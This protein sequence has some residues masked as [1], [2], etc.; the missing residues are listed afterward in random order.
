MAMSFARTCRVCGTSLHGP[1]GHV[2]HLFGIRRSSRN[3]NVCN[4]CDAHFQDSEVVEI[5]ILFADLSGFT[6]LTNTVGPEKSFEVLQTFFSMAK[7]ALFHQD[8]YIDKFIGDAVM[9]FFN[10]PIRNPRHGVSA[11]K[12]A[13]A[14]QRGMQ[15]VSKSIGIDLK[16]RIGVASGRAKL[17]RL[18]GDEGQDFTVIGEA[19]NLAS[20]LQSLAEPGEILID[21]ATFKQCSGECQGLEPEWFQ[22]KGFD[23]PVEAYRVD[24]AR[25]LMLESLLWVA[26]KTLR[27]RMGLGSIL[28]TILGAPCA[29]AATLSPLSVVLGVVAATGATS[30]FFHWLDAAPI[31][32]PLQLLGVGGALM[33]LLVIRHAAWR[34]RKTKVG[35]MPAGERRKVL[36]VAALS[37]IALLAVALETYHHIF[38]KGLSWFGP[39]L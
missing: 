21:T 9:A 39:P 4:R 29:I 35:E 6:K 26:P 37:C 18:G 32:I 33:N 11:L 20:R 17:G 36:L 3:P 2:F 5:T 7:E 24:D 22:P 25:S 10:V 19:V 8:A 15:R 38:V 28:F 13:I 30:T 1:L 34:R 12:A 14:I 23:A 31:R 27:E 16:A